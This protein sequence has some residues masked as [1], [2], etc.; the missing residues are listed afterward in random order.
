LDEKNRNVANGISLST[1]NHQG[2]L[3]KAVQARIVTELLE[4]DE[5]SGKRILA[6]WK[7]MM[8]IPGSELNKEFKSLDEY[9]D[10]PRL[11]GLGTE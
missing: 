10:K 4:S 2:S 3:L 8:S 1:S 7:R 5:V 9:L 6:E 11:L